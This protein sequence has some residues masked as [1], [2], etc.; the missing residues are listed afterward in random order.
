MSCLLR[1]GRASS[2]GDALSWAVLLAI[3]LTP[4]RPA[5]RLMQA[6][7]SPDASTSTE[8]RTWHCQL[9]PARFRTVSGVDVFIP[10]RLEMLWRRGCLGAMLLCSKH[11]SA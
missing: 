6:G 4:R 3:L 5:V 9:G 2:D 8:S 11:A 1:H 10:G 7:S